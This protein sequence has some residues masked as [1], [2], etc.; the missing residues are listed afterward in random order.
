MCVYVCVCLFIQ[1][2]RPITLLNVDCKILSKFFSNYKIKKVLNEITNYDQVGFIKDRDIGEAVRLIEN[3]L[4]YSKSI[5]MM[6]N[7]VHEIVIYVYYSV[8]L[9]Q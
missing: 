4:F 8:Y 2:Y 3:I 6:H 9:E 1:N 7:C 5:Y